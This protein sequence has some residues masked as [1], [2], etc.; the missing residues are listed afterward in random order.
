MKDLVI[1]GAGVTGSAIAR[2]ASKYNLDTV[3]VEKSEDVCTGTSKANSAIAHAGF[4]AANGT[5]MAKYNLEGSLMMEDLCRDLDIAYKR[6]GSL[7]V[8]LSEEDRPRLNALYENGVKNGVKELRI[9]EREE[10][11]E[12]EPNVSDNA[13]AALYAPT[14]AIVCPFEL[15][16]GLAENAA[17]NGVEFRFN[18]EVTGLTR[19]EDGTWQVETTAGT[20]DTRAVVNAAGVY[21]D[22]FHNMVAKEKIHITPRKGEYMLL[23]REVTGYVRHTVFQLPGVLGKGVLVSPTVHGNVIVGPTALDIENPEGTNTTLNGLDNV[24]N[25]S[26][27]AMKNV[28]LRKVITSFA[29][30]RAHED[31]HEFVLGEV[32]EAPGFFDAAGIE[33]PGLTSA[34]AIGREIAREV[35]EKLGATEKETFKA[36]RKGIVK[37]A[38]LSFE[39]RSALIKKNPAYGQIICRC[40]SI[41]EGEIIDAIRRP[42]GAKSLDGVKRRVRAGM[43]RCQAGFCSPRVMEILAREL[44]VPVY[45][46][47]KAGGHSK[48][49]TGVLKDNR[50]EALT[51]NEDGH[52]EV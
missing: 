10:L 47:T 36:T 20:L 1:I 48:I 18:T 33:S 38:S 30:L 22:K 50:E 6:N 21:S 12:M 32:K 41:S 43:G 9:V 19:K 24:T 29:G 26:G 35:A 15:T 46:I 14:G 16:I 4:D 7:V 3:V 52:G 44:G 34:P 27:L 51:E 39:E 8:C 45:E 13:V 2:F 49:I 31:R 37:A 28:P 17:E 40:E 11:C 25:K 5:L 23:D 42:L